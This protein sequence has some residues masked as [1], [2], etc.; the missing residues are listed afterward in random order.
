MR[1]KYFLH[2]A[3]FITIIAKIVV[4]LS[5]AQS[6]AKSNNSPYAER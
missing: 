1:W 6:V 4:S 2:L 5:F 3:L